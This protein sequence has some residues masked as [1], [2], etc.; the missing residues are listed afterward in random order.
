M[1]TLVLDQGWQPH[2]VVSWQR[3]VGMLFG[4]KVEVVEEYA[5]EIRSVSI[6]IRMP[7]VVRLLRTVRR[8]TTTPRLTRAHV[9]ARDGFCC[10][11]CGRRMTVSQSTFDHVLPRSR[12]GTTSWENIVAACRGCNGRKGGRTPEEAGMRLRVAPRH[13]DWLPGVT[14][15]M[16]VSKVPDAWRTWLYWNGDFVDDEDPPKVS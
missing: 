14:I 1:R 13:P 16:T 11:Y 8:R 3:A 10:Q 5:E 2:R 6:T 15:A 7:A 9:L 12:G 4:G